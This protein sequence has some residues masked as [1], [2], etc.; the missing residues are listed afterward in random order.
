MGTFYVMSALLMIICF[1][2]GV[3]VE[4]Y[5][6]EQEIRALKT[7]KVRPPKLDKAPTISKGHYVDFPATR[8]LR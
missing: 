8:K 2:V 1:C 7:R 5:F 3:Q 4:K 6:A